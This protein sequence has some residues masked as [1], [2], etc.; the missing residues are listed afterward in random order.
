MMV[1]VD[2]MKSEAFFAVYEH[3]PKKVRCFQ[4]PPVRL[5]QQI[6]NVLSNIEAFS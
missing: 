1:M 5:A 2:V 3:F 6:N 4:L